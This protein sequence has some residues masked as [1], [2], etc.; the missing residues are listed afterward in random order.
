MAKGTKQR[1]ATH[2]QQV[3]L[4]A[5]SL[6]NSDFHWIYAS[7]LTEPSNKSQQWTHPHITYS[8]TT[9]TSVPSFI[10][11]AGLL[12]PLPQHL[13]ALSTPS[14]PTRIF[15]QL[16]LACW[17]AKRHQDLCR[18]QGYKNVVWLARTHMLVAQPVG[19]ESNTFPQPSPSP[20]C[21]CPVMNS[22]SHLFWKE[23]TGHRG[24]QV[25][26]DPYALSPYISQT[27]CRNFVYCRLNCLLKLDEI[28]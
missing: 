6:I 22:A 11:T 20:S 27:F 28:S 4:W 7:W 8:P 24:G 2:Y 10:L 25:S 23:K 1:N 26:V 17:W 14:S 13:Y 19:Q 12:S 16:S 3:T 9:I 5:S 18:D 15:Q 21:S